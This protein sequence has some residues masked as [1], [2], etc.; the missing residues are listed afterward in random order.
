M[1]RATPGVASPVLRRRLKLA[2]MLLAGGLV[3]EAMTLQ[4]AH[5][6][7]FLV[8]LLLGIALVVAGIVVYLLALI[9][10]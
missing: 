9:S 7:A 10:D 4:W 2:G 3:V 6:T 5:P 1:S 8:F